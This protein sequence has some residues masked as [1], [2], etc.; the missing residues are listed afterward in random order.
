VRAVEENAA[1][2]AATMAA[3][4]TGIGDIESATAQVGSVTS[5]QNISVDHLAESVTAAISRIE[6]M[7]SLTEQLE[8]RNLPRAPVTG[9]VRL[10]FGDHDHTGQ[11][12]DLSETGLRCSVP[13][14]APMRDGDMLDAHVPL[15]SGRTIA[16]SAEVVHYR[17]DDLAVEVGLRFKDVPLATADA[18]AEV[19]ISGLG[20]SRPQ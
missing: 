6:T 13:T 12:I 19:V 8:R 4:T 16:V 20:L 10:T 5:E 14:D 11:L 9:S 17:A 15:G 1:A 2:M 18:I 7:V 3:M